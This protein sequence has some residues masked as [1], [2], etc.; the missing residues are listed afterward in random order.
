LYPTADD[1]LLILFL[2]FHAN[3]L[4]IAMDTF[5]I[6]LIGLNGVFDDGVLHLAG[7]VLPR[8]HVQI[9]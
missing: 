5:A 2:R 6:R 4:P 1:R 7:L 9:A 8:L 3:I